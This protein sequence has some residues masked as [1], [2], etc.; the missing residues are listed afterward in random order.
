MERP[1][2]AQNLNQ[3][4]RYNM[5]SQTGWMMMFTF[6]WFST[7]CDLLSTCGLHGAPLFVCDGIGLG[8]A[9][10]SACLWPRWLPAGVWTL[11]DVMREW[12]ECPLTNS[13]F[14]LLHIPPLAE[15]WDYLCIPHCFVPLHVLPRLRAAV[16]FRLWSS[17]VDECICLHGVVINRV[18]LMSMFWNHC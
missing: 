7:V 14:L 18:G 4:Q 16:E 17:Y 1:G 15:R 3:G 11:P 5:W 13:P 10:G 9:C 2:D 6:S 8:G 12:N